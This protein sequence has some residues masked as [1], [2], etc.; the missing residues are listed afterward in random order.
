MGTRFTMEADFFRKPFREWGMSVVVPPAE[1]QHFIHEK[2]FSEIELGIIKES[3]RESLL[4]IVKRMIERDAVDSLILGCT[5]LPLILRWRGSRHPVFE[6]NSH[7]CGEY[8]QVL[9]GGVR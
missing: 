7:S 1:E 4:S 9:L 8:R 2:L 6:Y 3:T 5:E